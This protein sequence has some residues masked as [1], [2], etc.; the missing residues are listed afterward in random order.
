MLTGLFSIL[1]IT[2]TYWIILRLFNF[3]S[4]PGTKIV[5]YIYNDNSPQY[6]PE[7]IG[8]ILTIIFLYI[9]GAL[10]SNVIGKRLSTWFERLI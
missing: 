10:I 8:F 2:V 6:V 9:I 7:L 4:H 3:F 1:P 5:E